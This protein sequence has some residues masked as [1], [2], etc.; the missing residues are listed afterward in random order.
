MI[1]TQFLMKEWSF[2][3][4][5]TIFAPLIGTNSFRC[6]PSDQD[7][8]GCKNCPEAL[9][10][11]RPDDE[12]LLQKLRQMLLNMRKLLSKSG[13]PDQPRVPISQR[14]LGLTVDVQSSY[15]VFTGTIP[16]TSQEEAVQ[17][18]TVP[19]WFQVEPDTL[20][21]RPINCDVPLFG[22]VPLQTSEHL[23]QESPRDY[24]GKVPGRYYRVL[25]SI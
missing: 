22:G 25:H 8:A 11:V 24:S 2:W 1:E 21:S 6:K 4:A 13:Q 20:V 9:Q 3:N 15:S 19:T 7:D 18:Y 5:D 10:M 17:Q 14:V 23:V 16:Q 12:A